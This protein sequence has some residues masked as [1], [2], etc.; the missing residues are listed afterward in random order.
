ME[1]ENF[2]ILM[3]VSIV[4]IA[5]GICIQIRRAWLSK[6]CTAQT[7]GTVVDI[8]ERIS[9]SSSSDGDSRGFGRSSHTVETVYYHPVF[10]Y[11]ADGQTITNTSSFGRTPAKF[12]IGQQVTVFYDPDNVE[13]Y[14]VA[15][16]KGAAKFGLIFAVAGGVFAA[17]GVIAYLYG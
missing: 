16:D 4:F 1:Y 14:F 6:S 9:I 8:E 13:K 7:E 11:E 12:V 15:E 3:V 17:V 5:V 2:I 10:Q